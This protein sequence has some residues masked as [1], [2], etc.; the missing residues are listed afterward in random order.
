ME[1]KSRYF[2]VMFSGLTDD[3]VF[4]NGK[5]DYR[6]NNGKYPS[7]VDL[8]M[9]IEKGFGLHQVFIKPPHE[10]TEADWKDFTEGRQE[11]PSIGEPDN[12]SFL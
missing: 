9:V 4:R 2:V 5:I 3:N 11:P 10:F 7:E 6:T 8:I 1:K 12:E